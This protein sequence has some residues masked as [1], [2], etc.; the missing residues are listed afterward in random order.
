MLGEIMLG[1]VMLEH[2]KMC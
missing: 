2:V 1:L